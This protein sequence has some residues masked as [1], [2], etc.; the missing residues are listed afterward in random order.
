MKYIA[1]DFAKA[2]GA[3]GAREILTH[4][5]DTRT[6]ELYYLELRSTTNVTALGLGEEE[7]AETAVDMNLDAHTLAL[8]RLNPEYIAAC[9]GA[10]EALLRRTLLKDKV[11]KECTSAKQQKNRERVLRK[12]CLNSLLEAAHKERAA[13][14]T[15]ADRHLRKEEFL[16]K[17]SDFNQRLLE[18]ALEIANDPDLVAKI[19]DPDEILA[20]SSKVDVAS[21]FKDDIE[22]YMEPDIEDQ[23]EENQDQVEV[24][25]ENAYS[26][27]FV[28]Y[29]S[30]LENVPYPDGVRSAMELLWESGPEDGQRPGEPRQCPLCLDDDTMTEEDGKYKLH[31]AK[32]FTRHLHTQQHSEFSKLLRKWRN[33]RRERQEED[34]IVCEFCRALRPEKEK[35]Q[36]FKQEKD[37]RKHLKNSN[38][39]KIWHCR[40]GKAKLAAEHEQAKVAAG[41]N[42]ADFFGDEAAIEQKQHHRKLRE[43]RRLSNIVRDPVWVFTEEGP[44]PG[45]IDDEDT[46]G[47]VSGYFG[48]HP[49]PHQFSHLMQLD[50]PSNIEAAL[51][52]S[53]VHDDKFIQQ[54]FP[55]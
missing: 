9:S 36:Y 14:E 40:W 45:P 16:R 50:T 12:S 3:D 35:M 37:L 8:D 25:E 49:G 26:E 17:S 34:Q 23:L 11:W 54:A 52:A 24:L 18:R 21:D 39:T 44:L 22:K 1:T 33:L 2:I 38:A 41:W 15:S 10:L 29:M 55:E 13:T 7:S 6:L 27:E 19:P 5:P 51:S 4:E 53:G 20:T 48:P 30:L 42:D 46:F 47:L 43:E 32:N 31:P 28:D